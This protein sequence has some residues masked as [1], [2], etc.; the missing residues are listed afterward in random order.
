MPF[1]DDYCEACQKKV[2]NHETEYGILCDGCYEQVIGSLPNQRER[3]ADWLHRPTSARSQ[4]RKVDGNEEV[5]E[6]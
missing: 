2:A 5:Q 1:P 6:G 4:D 3:S